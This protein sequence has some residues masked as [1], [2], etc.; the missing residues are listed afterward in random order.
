MDV[1][2]GLRGGTRDTSTGRRPGSVKTQGHTRP[3]VTQAGQ[4]A[5]LVTCEPALNN[6]RAA[7]PEGEGA[8]PTPSGGATDGEAHRTRAPG[9][10]GALVMGD[11]PD[12]RSPSIATVITKIQRQETTPAPG[13]GGGRRRQKMEMSW[14]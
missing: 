7:S 11:V 13:E 12:R 5:E 9:G 8:A 6:P 14:E 3:S 10:R 4:V 2:T 1:R